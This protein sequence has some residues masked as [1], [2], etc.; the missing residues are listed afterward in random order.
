MSTSSS[1]NASLPRCQVAVLTPPGRGAV[2]TLAVF[3]T[4]AMETV[5]RLF[6]PA[7]GTSLRRFPVNRVIYGHWG[8]LRTERT[9]ENQE[10]A[11][12]EEL[13]VVRRDEHTI[14][15]HCHGG[16]AAVD[17][18]VRSLTARNCVS[19]S[20]EF[21]VQR[22]TESRL[23][24]EARLAITQ[25]RTTRVAAILLDQVSGSLSRAVN[26]A[27][28]DLV[29][30]NQSRAARTLTAL[31]HRASFG[32][33]LISPWRVAL[34]G[35]TNVGKSSLINAL[36]G[37]DRALVRETAGTTRDVLT[38]VTAID[39]WPVELADTAGLRPTD[40]VIE[41]EGVRRARH[42]AATADLVLLVTDLTKPWQPP[43]QQG[44]DPVET[45]CLLVH[46]KRD[47]ARI[48]PYDRPAGVL[49]S[50]R[51]ATGIEDLVAEISRYLVP[52][53]PPAGAP[54]PF[55]KHHEDALQGS[56]EALKQGASEVAAAKLQA[57]LSW[58]PPS[59]DGTASRWPFPRGATEPSE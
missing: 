50:A 27:L 24:G 10:P 3:G 52:H 40:S 53:V 45:P 16:S 36:L 55:L 32:R 17:R 38:D 51:E 25:A 42:Q 18:V 22:H 23:N 31:L 15:V 19:V 2:A 7:A 39:G 14:E 11:P 5:E 57:I 33:R 8:Q 58:T 29:H 34:V 12:P 35:E 6:V 37:Y 20:P 44:R 41:R 48:P 49:T 30:Q 59:V 4:S 28:R 26:H 43:G 56:L 1:S 13:L 21:W 46:N 54:V 47:L 9:A